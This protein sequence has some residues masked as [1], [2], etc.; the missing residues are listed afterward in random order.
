M[1]GTCK[2]QLL[3]LPSSYNRGGGTSAPA[4]TS[5]QPHPDQRSEPRLDRVRE[6]S[7]GARQNTSQNSRRGDAGEGGG[8]GGGGGGAGESNYRDLDID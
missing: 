7:G 5:T 6:E 2:A 3:S 8:G 1:Y 4:A